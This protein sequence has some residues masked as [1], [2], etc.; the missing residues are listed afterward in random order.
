MTARYLNLLWF[1]FLENNTY[2][3]YVDMLTYDCS[4]EGLDALA[5]VISSK[6]GIN[7][8]SALIEKVG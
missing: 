3:E 2:P 1:Y 8:V 4:S 6:I 7:S 5:S